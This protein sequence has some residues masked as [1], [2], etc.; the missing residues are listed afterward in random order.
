MV[1]VAFALMT[2]AVAL[3]LL[4]PLS[5]RPGARPGKTADLDFYRSQLAEVQQDIDRGLV[6]ADDADATRAEIGRRLLASMDR[7][8]PG[9]SSGGFQ[10]RRLMAVLAAVVFVPA[11]ALGLYLHVGAPDQPDMPIAARD[12]APGFD[13][14]SAIP[15]IEAHL[16]AVPTD[17]R[18]FQ[19][20]A[21]IYLRLGRYEDAA[22]AYAASLRLLGEI[23]EGRAALGQAQMMVADGVVTAE[24]RGNFEKALAENPKLP[25]ARFFLAVAAEQDGN[26]DKA[27]QLF[28]ALQADS[29]AGAPWL[30][31]VRQRLAE[32]SGT[33]APAL[34][35]P[36][37]MGAPTGPA[38][39]GIAA[40]PPEQRIAAIRGMVDGLAAR[41]AENGRDPEGWLRLI[42][43]YTVLG[44]QDK[45]KTALADARKGL[46][47]DAAAL[48]QI[49][50]L[51]KQLGLE[52]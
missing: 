26:K 43:A 24:A 14:A 37:A 11:L 3:C 45:A 13:L 35:A 52:G 41:L 39:A 23:P 17:G 22:R 36:P 50:Q 16:A 48:Q 6:A 44:D 4:W 18:G 31:A 15:K 10:A 7:G 33:P 29:P 49:D 9:P 47:G 46:G 28:E 21:P 40:L 19:L 51:A 12:T 42:R 38:A 27:R 1:W 30:D 5:S 2:A 8:E 25:H 34:A 20:I 32:L